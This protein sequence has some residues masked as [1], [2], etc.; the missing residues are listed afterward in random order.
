M[1]SCNVTESSSRRPAME[2]GGWNRASYAAMNQWDQPRA[3]IYD[4]L[5]EARALDRVSLH[6]ELPIHV[7]MQEISPVADLIEDDSQGT[8]FNW[9]ALVSIQRD[10]TFMMSE[11]GFSISNDRIDRNYANAFIYFTHL[12]ANTLF[13]SESSLNRERAEQNRSQYKERIKYL[14]ELAKEEEDLDLNQQ[15]HEDFWLFINSIP[16]IRKGGLVLLDNGDLRALW[17]D[18]EGAHIGL[19]FRGAGEV[20]YV[21]FLRSLPA[22]DNKHQYGRGNFDLVKN[23]IKEYNL[24]SLVSE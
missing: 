7:Q 13:N 2:I 21:I 4:D 23:Q 19:Q 8:W 16:L 15:S 12:H 22:G 14:L 24:W 11:S 10:E 20:E 17:K 18:D 9:F 1:T 5:A 3:E 6:L